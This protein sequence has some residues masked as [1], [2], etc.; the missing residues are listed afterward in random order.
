M[1]GSRAGPSSARAPRVSVAR[2]L[3]QASGGTTPLPLPAL[4]HDLPRARARLDLLEDRVEV[5]ALVG[6]A[7]PRV[8][9]PPQALARGLREAQRQLLHRTPGVARGETAAGDVDPDR[10]AL[11]VARGGR[12][13]EGGLARLRVV[14]DPLPERR[15]GAGEAR[16]HRV[17]AAHLDHALEAHLREERGQVAVEVG[18]ARALAPPSLAQEVPEGHASGGVVAAPANHEEH[19]DLER[20]LDVAAVAEAR[21]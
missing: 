1:R 18:E 17:G 20:P 14:E 16:R 12:E 4:E 15:Q 19:R 6:I 9:D 3:D 5:G 13:L 11:L 2:V 8:R 21:L 10:L 7:S